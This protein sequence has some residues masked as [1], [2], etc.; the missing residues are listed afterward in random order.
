MSNPD[1]ARFGDRS[2][3][4]QGLPASTDSA[5]RAGG[6]LDRL[7]PAVYEELRAVAHR[8]LAAHGGGGTLDTAA[9]VH[10]AYLK[11]A[12]GPG[13]S[14]RDRSHFFALASRVMRQILVD[15]ARGRAAMKRGGERRRITFDEQVLAA[16]EQA[17]AMLELDDALAKLAAIAPRLARVVECKFFGGMGDEEIAQA[18]G[19]TD[20]TVRR[21]WEKARMLLRRALGE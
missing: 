12:G 18:L 2:G 4:P 21:D 15:R 17:D 19:I 10:E 3:S 6:D 11:L 7:I 8:R 1:I 13:E 5:A 20:R 14:W 16:D 9:L